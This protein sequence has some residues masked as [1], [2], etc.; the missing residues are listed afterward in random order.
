MSGNRLNGCRAPVHPLT[1]PVVPVP[2][3]LRCRSA[4]WRA[5]LRVAGSGPL[6]LGNE[7]NDKFSK[8]QRFQF[9]IECHLE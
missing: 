9:E 7:A 8:E 2:A 3:L 5:V 6:S 4:P 1:A